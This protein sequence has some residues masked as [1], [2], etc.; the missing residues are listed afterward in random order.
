MSTGFG[1]YGASI[2]QLGSNAAKA[3]LDVVAQ[4]RQGTQTCFGTFACRAH[5]STQA[6]DLTK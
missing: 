1:A 6:Q 4:P 5:R 3:A 2:S